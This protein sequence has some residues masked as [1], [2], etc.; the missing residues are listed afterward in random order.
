MKVLE[1]AGLIGAIAFGV[2][3]GHAL[4]WVLLFWLIP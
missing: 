1:W 3:L 2:L 4:W